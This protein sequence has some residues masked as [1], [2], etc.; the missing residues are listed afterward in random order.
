MSSCRIRPGKDGASMASGNLR[1]AVFCDG[2]WMS[3]LL[4][5]DVAHFLHPPSGFGADVKI[6]VLPLFVEREENI[7]LLDSKEY[8]MMSLFWG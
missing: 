4:P 8:F 6:K 1:N 5:D 3:F 7:Y 2:D